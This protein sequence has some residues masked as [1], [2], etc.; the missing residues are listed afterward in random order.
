MS[1][2]PERPGLGDDLTHLDMAIEKLSAVLM[3]HEQRLAPVLEP[4]EERP[5]AEG[6]KEDV[7]PEFRARAQLLIGRIEVM[8]GT[9]VELTRRAAL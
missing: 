8:V 7:L 2:E 6:F 4:T 3:L 1:P 5:L 9:V